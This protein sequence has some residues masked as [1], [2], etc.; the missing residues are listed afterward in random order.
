MVPVPSGE[1]GLVHFPPMSSDYHWETEMVVAIAKGG[2]R[3]PAATAKEH[4]F[5]YGVGLDMTR[6]DLQQI[7]KDKGRP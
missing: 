3:I 4:V 5:G 6:R 1:L 2:H 7:G